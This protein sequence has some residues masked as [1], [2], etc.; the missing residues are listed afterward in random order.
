MQKKDATLEELE[1]FAAEQTLDITDDE[2]A[3]IDDAMAEIEKTCADNGYNLPVID[4]IV[5]AKTTQKEE[6]DASAYT[7]GTQIY[8]GQIVFDLGMSDDESKNAYFHEIMAHELFHCLTRNNPEFREKMYGVLG[9]TVVDKDYVFPTKIKDLIISNPD[10]E[11]HNSYATFKING[12]DKD[13]VVIFTTKDKFQKPGD[14]F[15]DS[16][17][18][19]LVPIDDLGTMYTSD[20]AS[21]FWEVFGENT[22]YVIDPEETMADNFS[23]LINYGKDGKDYKTPEIIDKIEALLK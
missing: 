1:K 10:V 3:L 7:H 23:Y 14:S 20:D 2:K 12:E 18:T 22:D 13:C 17:V 9:F 4:G 11:Y 16:M 6:C 19:G 5:F 21:N 8:L 15:F